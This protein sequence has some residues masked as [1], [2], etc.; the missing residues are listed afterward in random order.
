MTVRPV[1]IAR[2]ITETE[3]PD[4]CNQKLVFFSRVY[5]PCRDYSFLTKKFKLFFKIIRILFKLFHLVLSIVN[6]HNQDCKMKYTN[7][8]IAA[9]LCHHDKLRLRRRALAW[10]SW[11]DGESFKV[12][13]RRKFTPRKFEGRPPYETS[14]WGYML[15]N[16]RS[17]DPSDR[18]DGQLFRRRFRVPFP[19]FLDIVKMTRENKWFSEKEDAVGIKAA[20]LELKILAVLRVLGRV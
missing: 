19:V 18:K 3:N 20:P 17:Q 9:V 2:L 14:T 16:P 8:I 4:S 11:N 7:A 13:R 1:L 5:R 6:L 12:M 10:K 15:S